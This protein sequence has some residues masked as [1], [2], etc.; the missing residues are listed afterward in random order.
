MEQHM[1]NLKNPPTKKLGKAGGKAP[2]K[3]S[4]MP[5]PKKGLNH[6]VTLTRGGRPIHFMPSQVTKVRSMVVQDGHQTDIQD[7]AGRTQVAEPLEA[8]LEA[9]GLNTVKFHRHNIQGEPHEVY[10]VADQVCRVKEVATPNPNERTSIT[11]ATGD[12]TVMEPMDVVLRA[13]D[14]ALD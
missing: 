6:F 9:L 2:S 10:F 5:E 13:I 8:V 7:R 1:E 3:N 4:P 11:D 12:T 14:N